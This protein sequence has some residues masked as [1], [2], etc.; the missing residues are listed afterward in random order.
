[1]RNLV[2]SAIAFCNCLT[3]MCMHLISF[4]QVRVILWEHLQVGLVRFPLLPLSF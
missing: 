3:E 2:F 1:L 4:E